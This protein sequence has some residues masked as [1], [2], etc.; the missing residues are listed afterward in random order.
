MCV[1]SL[2][3]MY[4]CVR[5]SEKLI[6]VRCQRFCVFDNWYVRV[7]LHICRTGSLSLSSEYIFVV[8]VSIRTCVALACVWELESE[9]VGGGRVFNRH[10]MCSACGVWCFSST[11]PN[12]GGV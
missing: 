10:C 8:H 4:M 2:V 11:S 5:G 6:R 9:S 7:F 1:C 3:C 12:I